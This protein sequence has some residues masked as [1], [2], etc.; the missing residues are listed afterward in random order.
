MNRAYYS[1]Y[2]RILFKLDSLDLLDKVKVECRNQTEKPFKGSH[3]F[4]I[5]YFLDKG[6]SKKVLRP[7][8]NTCAYN[9]KRLRHQADYKK[10]D[11]NEIDV[12]DAIKLAKLFKDLVK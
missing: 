5:E 2:Q 7:R 9:L 10:D 4:T 3:E 11:M 12:N 8:V 6:L 1:L